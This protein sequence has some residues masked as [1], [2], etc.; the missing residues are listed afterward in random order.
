MAKK[1]SWFE[2]NKDEIYFNIINSLL[3][4]LLVFF[5]SLVGDQFKP[6]WQ[7]LGFAFVTAIIV[8]ITKFR[9]Y[10]ATQEKELCEDKRATIK[11]GFFNFIG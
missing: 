1:K 10:W 6:S 8:M 2:C 5:G 3:A 11:M 9:D 7:G 4:G